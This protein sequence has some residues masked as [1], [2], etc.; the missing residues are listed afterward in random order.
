MLEALESSSASWFEL[1]EPRRNQLTVGL[2]M[3]D[4][5]RT[6]FALLD[7]AV[8][9]LRRSRGT[10]AKGSRLRS[11]DIVKAL[12]TD[13]QPPAMSQQTQSI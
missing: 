3:M 2:V 8:R 6:S 1:S 11:Q 12:L 13:V 10:V 4:A 9:T 7:Q 5:S